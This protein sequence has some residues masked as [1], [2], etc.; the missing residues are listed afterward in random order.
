MSVILIAC[1][2]AGHAERL[3]GN[4]SR[5]RKVTHLPFRQAKHLLLG[6]RYI[7]Y[8]QGGRIKLIHKLL[9]PV[10]KPVILIACKKAGHAERLNGNESRMRKVTHLPFRQAKHLLLGYRYTSLRTG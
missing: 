9:A 10:K 2:K 4:E 1:K 7:R 6:Y 3:N 5:M 8:V